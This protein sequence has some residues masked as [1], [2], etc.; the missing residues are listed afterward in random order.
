MYVILQWYKRL[1]MLRLQ[2]VC[3]NPLFQKEVM[4]KFKYS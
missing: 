2:P 1:S 3:R 4:D